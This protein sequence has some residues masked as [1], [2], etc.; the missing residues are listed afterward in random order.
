MKAGRTSAGARAGART[1]RARRPEGAVPTTLF[2]Q[3]GVLRVDTLEELLD[4]T[5]L[6]AGQP[7]P[8]DA[9]SGC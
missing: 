4:V 9:T 3:A 7:L 8:R 5:G 1:Q 2:H 6:L